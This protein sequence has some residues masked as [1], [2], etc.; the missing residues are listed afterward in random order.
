M[1]QQ[2]PLNLRDDTELVLTE[3][4]SEFLFTLQSRGIA[5]PATRRVSKGE[6]SRIVSCQSALCGATRPRHLQ[7]KST[8]SRQPPL[9]TRRVTDGGQD[10]T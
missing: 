3:S 1:R 4:V 8:R 2:R 9:L 7:L 10:D 6:R 5:S